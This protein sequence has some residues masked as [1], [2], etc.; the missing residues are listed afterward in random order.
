VPWLLPLLA[1]SPIASAR[2]QSVD[3]AAIDRLRAD[4]G[5]RTQVSLHPAT[6]A[7]R[8]V[9]FGSDAALDTA[10][11]PV[12]RATSFLRRHGG[13]FGIRSVD[14]ELELV[15]SFRDGHGLAH[16]DYRQLYRGVPVFGGELRAHFR[17]DGTMLAIN[18]VFVP[19]IALETTPALSAAEGGRRA[20]AEIARQRSLA[21]GDPRLA[22]VD[23]ALFVYRLGLVDGASGPDRLVHRVVVAAP[24]LAL[25]ELVFVDARTGK[26]V[27]QITAAYEALDR[28]VSQSTVDN[29]VW[30]EGDDD[31][32]PPGWMGGEVTQVA[33]WQD[34]IDGARETYNFF[35]ALSGGTFLSYDGSSATMRTLHDPDFLPNC[36]NALWDGT[37]A[38]FCPGTTADDVVGHEWAHA[39]MDYTANLLYRWQSGALNESFS[40]LWGEVIDQVNGRGTDAPDLVRSPEECSSLAP[41]TPPLYPSQVATHR[42]MVGEDAPTL[43]GAVRDMWRPSCFFHPDQVSDPLYYCESDDSG[44]VHV[45]S[46]IPNR[47]FALLVDGADLGSIEVAG[48]GLTKATHLEWAAQNMLTLISSFADHAD[49]LEAACQALVGTDLMELTTESTTPPSSGQALAQPDCAELADAIAA[50][51]LR[52]EPEQCLFEPLLDPVAPPL[53]AGPVDTLHFN[54]FEAGLGDWT[55]GRRAVSE[56]STFDHD[57]WAV[58]GNLPD[59]RPGLAAFAADDDTLGNCIGDLEAGIRF[60]E[61]PSIVVGADQAPRLAFDHWLSTEPFIDGGNVKVSVDGGAWQLVPGSAFSFNAYN[62]SLVLLPINDNP[63]QSEEAFTG[64]DGGVTSGSWGQSQV[65]LSGFAG[66]G[67]SLKLRFELGIDSCAG[68]IGWYVD[69]VRV[70][71]CNPCGDLVLGEG[72]ACDDGNADPGDGCSASCQVEEGWS[73]SD[74]LPPTPGQNLLQDPG[75]EAA[76]ESSPWSQGTTEGGL[77]PICDTSCSPPESQS[78][79]A[80]SGDGYAWFGHVGETVEEVEQYVEQTVTIPPAALPLRLFVKMPFCDSMFDFLDVLVDGNPE[81]RLETDDVLCGSNVYAERSVD[82][83]E[84]ADGGSHVLRVH[85]K[86]SEANG[87]GRTAIFVDDLTFDDGSGDPP[88]PSLCTPPPIFTDGF[89]SGDVSAWSESVP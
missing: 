62:G 80:R 63:M 21:D 4:A 44:G 69:D 70:F 40:D 45:N 83:G 73:C 15:R 30:Q 55:A 25:R 2:A 31:P 76:E 59:A 42:W 35:A 64:A 8:F 68:G 52:G 11:T 65:D 39:Y 10:G 84:Y 82:L 88:Q 20:R 7:V 48:I 32:I 6:G 41:R 61:T 86:T 38:V 29:V 47:L 71:S 24:E 23:S 49:A 37:S 34:E 56:P 33:G 3:P 16:V 26:I 17:P 43:S 51:E 79:G 13:A 18:G 60:L 50:V 27:D 78:P 36:N 75:F 67:Q 57:D 22:V 89:E 72:E 87:R 85:G 53:C 58:V 66:P 54:D 14:E 46:G 9:R 28:T 19:Q 74:P 81:L 12:E 5:D 1:G 77:P